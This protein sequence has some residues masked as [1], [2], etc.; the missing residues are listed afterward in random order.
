MSVAILPTMSRHRALRVE[1]VKAFL[2]SPN[3]ALAPDALALQRQ[4]GALACEAV[5]LTLFTRLAVLPMS[6]RR[7]GS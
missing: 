1:L 3:R 4:C 6:I 5:P 7:T 2:V